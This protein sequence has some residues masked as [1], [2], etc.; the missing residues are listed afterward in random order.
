MVSTKRMNSANSKKVI[1]TTLALLAGFASIC[2]LPSQAGNEN[3]LK[4]PTNIVKRTPKPVYDCTPDILLIMPNAGADTDEVSDVLKDAKGTIVGTM[5]TGKLTCII[6]K[7]EK[8]HMAETEKKLMKDKDHFS[9]IGRNYKFQAQIVPN[10]PQFASEWHLGAIN[11]PSAWNTVS[12][13]S[14]K[15][16]IFDSGCQSTNRDLY[17]KTEKGYNAT[18]FW[19]H[20]TA[21]G[22]DGGLGHLLGGLGGSLSSGAQT[23]VQGHGTFVATTAAASFNNGYETAGVAPSATVY[24]IQ[25]A[26]SSG[27]ADD[28]S[29]MA[30]LLNAPEAG[31]KIVNISYGSAPPTGLT[32]AAAHAPLH[33]YMKDFHDNHNGLIF[34]SSGNNGAFDPNPPQP[35]LNVISAI[36]PTFSL[37]SFSNWG[38]SVTFTA[39]GQSIVCSSRDGSVSTVRGTSFSSPI[40]AS[41]AALVWS[42]NPS[43]SNNQVEWI[44]RASCLR[45]GSSPTTLFYGYGLPDASRAVSLATGH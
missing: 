11:A 29:M 40:V 28:I 44:L 15:I 39:P 30:G 17:G 43:L 23:D 32:N 34:I 31:C 9:C 38:P 6:Y 18:T 10:D 27:N 33:A 42:A 20:L 2:A 4:M 36:A 3:K 41:I 12:G 21:L 5:G 26:N 37:T 1:G 22:G 14:T 8:G 25:I 35:Y 16:G 24:P 13:R 7:T 45:A 19:A